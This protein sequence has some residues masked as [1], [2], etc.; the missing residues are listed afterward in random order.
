MGY[1][2]IDLLQEI[3]T[4]NISRKVENLKLQSMS[5]SVYLLEIKNVTYDVN[6]IGV[7]CNREL[8]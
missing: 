8:L 7:N 3:D 6:M 4:V 5:T 2:I 1:P